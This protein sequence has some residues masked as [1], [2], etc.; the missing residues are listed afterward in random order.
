MSSGLATDID[1]AEL[2]ENPW[3]IYAQL[4]REAPVT[5][6]PLSGEWLVTRW[7]DCDVVGTHEDLYEPSDD[8]E[9]RE[10][11]FGSPNVLT[12]SGPDHKG[13]R[14]GIDPHLRP[15]SVNG[16]IED[17]C[18]P[19]ARRFVEQVR[20]HGAADLTTEVYEPISVRV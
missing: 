17:L 14:Q 10:R 12:M 9:P 5:Y 16:Y 8:Y 7:D 6:F 1:P 2:D 18:R 11:V 19:I 4:R 20:E 3:P 15:R 13:L